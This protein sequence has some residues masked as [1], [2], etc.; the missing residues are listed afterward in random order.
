MHYMHMNTSVCLQVDYPTWLLPHRQV[1]EITPVAHLRWDD[2]PH[3]TWLQLKWL[4][5]P[6]EW[7]PALEAAPRSQ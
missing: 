2:P 5:L 4:M 3:A 6:S 7:V 1:G